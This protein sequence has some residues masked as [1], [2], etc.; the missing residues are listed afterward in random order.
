M[1]GGEFKCICANLEKQLV[2]WVAHSSLPTLTFGE[3]DIAIFTTVIYSCT[4][5]LNGG[6]ILAPIRNSRVAFLT[7]EFSS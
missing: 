1:S 2:W 6:V 5:T 4:A 7:A 3:T